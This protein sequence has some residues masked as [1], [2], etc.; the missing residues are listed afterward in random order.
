MN[1]SWLI[2]LFLR[3]WIIQ[4]TE[5]LEIKIWLCKKGDAEDVKSSW[6]KVEYI[7]KK[8]LSLSQQN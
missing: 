8:T 5:K 3:P 7:Y 6:K 1:L 2:V 4:K